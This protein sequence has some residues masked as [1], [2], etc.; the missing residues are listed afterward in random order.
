M[1]DA[2]VNDQRCLSGR[3]EG[4]AANHFGL[5]FSRNSFVWFMLNRCG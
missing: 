4:D 3:L 1:P 2:I 5:S